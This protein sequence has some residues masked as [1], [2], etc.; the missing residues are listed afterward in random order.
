VRTP[1]RIIE[2]HPLADQLSLDLKE[3]VVA[4]SEPVQ[5]T[6]DMLFIKGWMNSV[7]TYMA[8]QCMIPLSFIRSG[9]E[10]QG[11]DVVEVG[12]DGAV[13]VRLRYPARMIPI[14]LTIE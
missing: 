9:L 1:T 6:L 4:K 11:L 14:T 5:L 2:A 13:H 10:A 3:R 12:P 7:L 8:Q